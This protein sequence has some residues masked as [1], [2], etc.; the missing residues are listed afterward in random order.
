MHP[1]PDQPLP[2]GWVYIEHPDAGRSENPVTSQAA[3]SW[4]RFGWTVVEDESEPAVDTVAEPDPSAVAEAVA[5]PRR[6]RIAPAA[7]P[8]K[9]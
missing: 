4:A 7:D 8:V 6:A 1:L 5:S 2:E 9:E 3:A